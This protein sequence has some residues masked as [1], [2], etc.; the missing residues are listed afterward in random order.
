MNASFE[1]QSLFTAEKSNERPPQTRE[2]ALIWKLAISAEALIPIV[3]KNDET[4]VFRQSDDILCFYNN[5]V[6]IL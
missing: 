4:R 5:E 3:S 6:Y 1:S 2:G